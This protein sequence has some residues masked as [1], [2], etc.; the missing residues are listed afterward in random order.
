MTIA[1]LSEPARHRRQREVLGI[2]L[3]DLAPI[4]RRRY[5]RVRLR[6]HRVR[7]G[8]SAIF[9]VLVV[10]EEDAVALLLPPLARCERRRTPLDLARERQRRAADLGER[11]AALDADVDVHPARAGR[12]GPA[13]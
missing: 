13:D 9:R 7:G 6:P 10:V 12:L 3:R 5:P 1:H 8:N 11:P 4:E 2:A